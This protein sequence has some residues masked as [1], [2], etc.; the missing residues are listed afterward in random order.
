[1]ASTISYL[2]NAFVFV[3]SGYGDSQ[4]TKPRGIHLVREIAL[5]IKPIY[6]LHLLCVARLPMGQ[7]TM[8]FALLSF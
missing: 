3:G 2:D 8:A 6:T 7:G 1:M 5:A 4:V